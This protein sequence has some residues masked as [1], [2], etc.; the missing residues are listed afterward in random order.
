MQD[1]KDILAIRAQV[2]S[3][4]RMSRDLAQVSRALGSAETARSLRRVTNPPSL[5]GTVRK[6]GVALA[7]AP[8]PFT[9]VAGLAMIAGSFTMKR[10]EPTSLRDL[11][12]E[13][14]AQSADLGELSSSSLAGLS[15]SLLW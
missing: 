14:A 3:A 6:A 2:E 8:E 11:A 15:L 4:E 9:T 1:N 10:R 5:S 7:L 13:A 12:E